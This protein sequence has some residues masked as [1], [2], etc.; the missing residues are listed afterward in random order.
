[1]T[2]MLLLL[3]LLCLANYGVL[4][5]HSGKALTHLFLEELDRRKDRGLSV[6]DRIRLKKKRR[7][8]KKMDRCYLPPRRLCRSTTLGDGVFAVK[9]MTWKDNIIVS[10]N[11]LDGSRPSGANNTLLALDTLLM[12][13]TLL[14]L[15]NAERKFAPFPARGNAGGRVPVTT[16]LFVLFV[17]SAVYPSSLLPSF[18][19]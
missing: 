2:I 4:P 1:M 11:Q 9:N 5:T 15:R 14:A 16:V 19:S 18:H 3:L 13:A 10:G 6:A 17:I 8:N 7:R 12:D